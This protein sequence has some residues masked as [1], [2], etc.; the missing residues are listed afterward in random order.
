[1]FLFGMMGSENTTRN[2]NMVPALDPR[3][4]RPT[5]T[6]RENGLGIPAPRPFTRQRRPSARA[7]FLPAF[8]TRTPLNFLTALVFFAGRFTAKNSPDFLLRLVHASH[9]PA[10]PFPTLERQHWVAH[11]EYL[12][13]FA[14]WRSSARSRPQSG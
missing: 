2:A 13:E 11:F 10:L 7:F 5:R 12:L 8:S 9:L 1:M 3:A 14:K 6:P 4:G